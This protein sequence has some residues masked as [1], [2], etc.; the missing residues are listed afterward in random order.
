MTPRIV[1]VMPVYN[2]EPYLRETVPAMLGQTMGDFGLVLFNNGSTD[3]SADLL[4]HYAERDAR[5]VYVASPKNLPPA[6]T[7]NGLMAIAMSEWK[8]CRWF[9]GAGADDLMAPDYLSAILR[10]T[11]DHPEANCIF[12]PWQWLGHPERGVHRF[13]DYDP[14]S[15]H[16]VHQVPAWHAFP[17]ELWEALGGHDSRAGIGTDWDWVVRASVQGLLRPYQLDRPYLALRV[18]EGRRSLSEQSHWPSLHRHLCG[19]ADQ[20]VPAWAR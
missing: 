13:P 19:I 9:L 12:S 8:Y 20:P 17:R 14:A 3:A 18:R 5:I 16:A 10:A 15:V 4:H 1:V 6:A 11:E 2:E 7:A